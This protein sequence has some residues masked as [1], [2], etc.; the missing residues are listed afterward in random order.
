M[1]APNAAGAL[2][3][4]A[5]VLAAL[6]SQCSGRSQLL[7]LDILRRGTPDQLE[8][9]A[10]LLRSFGAAVDSVSGGLALDGPVVLHGAEVNCAELRPLA[11]L[12]LAL[13]LLADSPSILHGMQAL[14]RPWPGLKEALQRTGCL[15]AQ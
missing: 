10:Q 5:P 15:V 1:L 8:L 11:Q 3:A 14:E 7:G 9:A 6:A 13:A 12:S 4:H 2:I